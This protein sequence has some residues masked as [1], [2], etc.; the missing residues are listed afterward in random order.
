MPAAREEKYRGREAI[1][2]LSRMFF[3]SL[4]IYSWGFFVTAMYPNPTGCPSMGKRLS[5]TTGY[6]PWLYQPFLHLGSY[7]LE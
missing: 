5:M 4:S 6:L 7:S 2:E 3:P 1:S